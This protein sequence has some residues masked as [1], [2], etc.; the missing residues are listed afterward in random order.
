MRSGEVTVL[1]P[2]L[3]EAETIGPLIDGLRSYGMRVLVVDNGSSDG[4]A[5]VATSRGAQVIKESRRGKGWAVM[6]GIRELATPYLVMMDADG[7]YPTDQVFQVAT[8]LDRF[9]V[10]MGERHIR[11]KGAMKPMNLLGNKLLSMAASLLYGHYTADLCTGMWG[12]RMEA[13]EKLELKS[14]GFTLEAELYTESVLRGCRIGRLPVIYRARP[15]KGGSHL[16][17]RHGLE[18]GWYLLKRRITG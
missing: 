6:R 8:M 9:D 14:A 5:A 11:L 3:N 16:R 18:I 4:T 17:L 15:N 2:A 7:T 1:L 10:V 13:I 12:F